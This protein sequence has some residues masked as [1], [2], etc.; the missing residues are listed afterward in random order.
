MFSASLNQT[1]EESLNMSDI[2]SEVSGRLSFRSCKVDENPAVEDVE[3]EGPTAPWCHESQDEKVANL[4]GL[5]QLQL[6][7]VLC[8]ATIEQNSDYVRT[9][10]Y[11]AICDERGF[12][13]D[14]FHSSRRL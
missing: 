5:A 11:V 10:K 14:I 3:T 4:N 13:N 2:I 12:F 8:F 1:V 6:H 9:A 7:L